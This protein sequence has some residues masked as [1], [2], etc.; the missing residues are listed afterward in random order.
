[1]EKFQRML[2]CYAEEDKKK[3]GKWFHTFDDKGNMEYQ[4]Q[5]LRVIFVNE[6]RYDYKVQLYSWIT[7]FAT[8]IVT[9]MEHE[10]DNIIL[11]ESD[12]EMRMNVI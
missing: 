2:R 7:G 12:E 5:I 6:C 10:M 3:R 1:M 4:G 11:Y 8:D 9:L